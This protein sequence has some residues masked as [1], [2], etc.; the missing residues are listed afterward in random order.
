MSKKL[1]EGSIAPKER[2]NIKYVPATGD[3][4][5]EVELP[6]NILVVGDIKGGK[7]D[8]AIEEREAISINKHNFDS[9]METAGLQLNF[10]VKN[11]LQDN[12]EEELPISLNINALN[13]FSPDNIARQVPELKKLLELREA[14]VALKGPLGNIPSFRAS[15]QKLLADGEMRAQLLKELDITLE[16]DNASQE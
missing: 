3:E 5:A 9:V 10:S 11:R 7:D 6:L 14:L 4:Q 8:S 2:I 15:L 1:Y 16:E 13:E 12:A